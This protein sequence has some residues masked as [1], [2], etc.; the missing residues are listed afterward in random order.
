MQ[1]TTQLFTRLPREIRDMV[2]NYLL[3]PEVVHFIGD[4]VRHQVNNNCCA[5]TPCAF[6]YELPHIVDSSFIFP[7]MTTE[8]MDMVAGMYASSNHDRIDA[9]DI[10]TFLT[11]QAL[12]MDVPASS[13]FSNVM[14]TLH[15]PNMLEQYHPSQES[16]DAAINTEYF[17][18]QIGN[19]LLDIPPYRDRILRIVIVEGEVFS[20]RD[21]IGSNTKGKDGMRSSI[22]GALDI[23]KARDFKW[24]TVNWSKEIKF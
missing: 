24:V 18:R 6:S 21:K 7:P 4:Q 1:F 17:Q 12:H 11:T 10:R 19:L 3:D 2:Y 23:V 13:F 8:V 9:K 5:S 15:L 14:V 20:P 16:S 22:R